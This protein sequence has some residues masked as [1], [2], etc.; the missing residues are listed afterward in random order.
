MMSALWFPRRTIPAISRIKTTN[1]SGRTM[2]GGRLPH[3][4]S[5]TLLSFILNKT[6]G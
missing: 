1:G 6:R 4:H 5:T 3:R 2:L